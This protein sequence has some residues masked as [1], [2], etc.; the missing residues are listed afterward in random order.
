MKNISISLFINIIFIVSFIAISST[1]VVFIKLDKERFEANR[2]LRYELI[3]DAFLSGFQFMPNDY[4][5]AKLYS[6]FDV[7]P[8]TDKNRK[9]DIITNS[10][11]DL[12]KKSPFGRV[13]LFSQGAEHYIYVQEIGYN[14][15]LKDMKPKPYSSK[16]ALAIFGTR[17][18]RHYRR[19]AAEA[20]ALAAQNQTL[21]EEN[22][23]LAQEV[24]R[25]KNDRVY[26]EKVARDQL[27]HVR[28]DETVFLVPAR[29]VS[30]K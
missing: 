30:E 17:G 11:T 27:G 8:V 26:I 28:P 15:L 9:I 14:I 29:D 21:A 20:E 1:F 6:H 22:Q 3:A 10:T 24:E 2:S 7:L 12:I 5:L 19:L 23:K 16:I 4:Q 18:L 25:L 13:R